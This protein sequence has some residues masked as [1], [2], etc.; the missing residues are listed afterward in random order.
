M[1]GSLFIDSKSQ[2]RD[3]DNKKRALGR[4]SLLERPHRRQWV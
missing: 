3:Y 1:D 2:L 4:V